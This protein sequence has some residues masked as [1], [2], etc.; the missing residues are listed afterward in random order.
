VIEIRAISQTHAVYWV[1]PVGAEANAGV[2]TLV[3]LANFYDCIT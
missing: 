2:V 1:R 3:D